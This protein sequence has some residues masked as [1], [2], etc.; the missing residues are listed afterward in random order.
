MV[1]GKFIPLIV[2]SNDQ[3]GLF[4]SGCGEDYTGVEKIPFWK[5]AKDVKTSIAQSIESR[6]DL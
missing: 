1:R 6:Y 5:L 2:V 3:I 4:V